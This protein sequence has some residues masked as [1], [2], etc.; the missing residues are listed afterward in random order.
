MA[1]EHRENS[2][3]NIHTRQTENEGRR[4]VESG[5]PSSGETLT[6]QVT[7]PLSPE[8]YERLFFQPNTHRGDLS[9]RLGNPTL[10]G[11]LGFLIPYQSTMLALLQTQGSSIHSLTALS[12]SYFLGGIV[13]V[14]AGIFELILG[15]TFLGTLFVT[16]GGR[17]Y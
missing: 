6:R 3:E 8:V 11:L 4:A 1:A 2:G 12:G 14:L 13:M 17:S 5:V 7:V 15:N 10:L 9:Q 16:Y